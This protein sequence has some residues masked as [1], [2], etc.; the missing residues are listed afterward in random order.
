MH[1]WRDS[2]PYDAYPYDRAYDRPYDEAPVLAE[3]VTHLVF[4]GGRLVR[5]WSEDAR[6]TEWRS[7]VER[8]APPPQPPRPPLHARVLDWL[9]EV[10]GGATAVDALDVVPLDDRSTRLPVGDDRA[11]AER[12]AETADLLDG[13]VER[14]F[15]AEASYAFRHALLMLWEDDP[16]RVMGPA[17]AARLAGGISWAVGRANGLFHPVGTGRVG[18]V[19]DSLGLSGGLS[20]PGNEVAGALRGFRG[21]GSTSWD[22]PYECPKLLPLGRPELLTSSTRERLVRLREQAR[23]AAA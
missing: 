4:V 16:T 2:L 9:A 14:W 5:T 8:P 10:C 1:D 17:S 13:V 21:R 19:Q 7:Y 11:S 15:D 18:Q 20:G 3:R 23:A 22:P 6:D 12:L